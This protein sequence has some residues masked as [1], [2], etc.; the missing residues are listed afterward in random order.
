MGLNSR[1]L[2]NHRV[3]SEIIDRRASMIDKLCRIA[4]FA[5]RVTSLSAVPAGS[6][7]TMSSV[8]T[9]LDR[10]ERGEY[11][12]VTAQLERETIGGTSLNDA[13]LVAVAQ[14]IPL[15]RRHLVVVFTDGEDTTSTLGEDL[16][17]EIA[18]HADAVLHA[19]L[20]KPTIPLMVRHMDAD[21]P[22][23]PPPASRAA[24]I[25]AA[26][27]TGTDAHRLDDAVAAFKTVFDDFRQSYVLRYRPSGVARSGWHTLSVRVTRTDGP[28]IVR[29]RRGYAGAE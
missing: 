12:A 27:R 14:P 29:A 26:T 15:D 11:E 7:P 2:P 4:G 9:L 23:K 21:E 3:S 6:R 13:I 22:A 8:T 17:P 28:Y 5:L 16:V 24:L 18:S 20:F 10:Y 19:V 1:S 25:E